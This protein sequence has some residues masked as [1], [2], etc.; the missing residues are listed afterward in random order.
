[1]QHEFWLKKWEVHQI[2]F[3]QDSYHPFLEKFWNEFTQ[4]KKTVFVPLCGKSK[5]MLFFAS[6]GHKVIGVEL[7]DIAVKEFFTENNIGYEVLI[8]DDFQVYKSTDQ[9]DDITIYC[10]DIFNLTDR[11]LKNIGYIYDRAALIALPHEMRLEYA[12]FMSGFKN[13]NYFLIT[14]EFD[15]LEV[16]PPFSIDAEMVNDYLGDTFKIETALQ[17]EV[18]LEK[19]GVHKGKITCFQSNLFYLSR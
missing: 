1:M 12:Q 6:Q 7:S 18:P 16:G 8:R 9:S 5:D 2:G 11:D 14:I 4:D 3:H 13:I 19:A 17:K 10:G 15:N